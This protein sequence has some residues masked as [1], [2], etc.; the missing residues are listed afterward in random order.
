MIS[1]SSGND[2]LSDVVQ[3]EPEVGVER[4]VV[5]RL[6]LPQTGDPRAHPVAGV[7]LGRELGDLLRQRRPRADQAHRAAEHVEQLRQLVEAGRPQE[8]PDARDPRVVLHLEQRTAALVGRRQLGEPRLG[9]DD[10]RAE[11]EDL[12]LGS[13]TADAD[14]PEEHR[15]AILE[16]DGEGDQ[17]EHRRRQHGDQ[18]G[19]GDVEGPLD[20]RLQAG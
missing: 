2:Q 6:D 5:A 4:R 3:V 8:A 19:H 14:L 15:A 18:A 10:H 16:L 13:V 11:L 1:R 7:E 12:E 20:A 17:G 9:V